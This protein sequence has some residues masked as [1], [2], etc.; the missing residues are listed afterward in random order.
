[1]HGD[2]SMKF[3]VKKPLRQNPPAN[4]I[5]RCLFA[6]LLLLPVQSAAA[7]KAVATL[8]STKPGGSASLTHPTWLPADVDEEMP[9]V[10]ETACS[11]DEVLQEAEESIL[12]FVRNVDRFTA[13]ESLTHQS[14]NKHGQAS[15][16][17]SRT[18]DYVVS[19][20]E[21]RQ[22]HLGVTEYR[23]GGLALNEFPGGIVTNGLP[24]LVLIFHP[25][26]AP[27]YEMTCEGLARSNDQLAWQVH[28]RQWPDKP[29]ELKTYQSGIHGASYPVALKGRAWISAESYQ[30]VRMETDL[31]APVPQIQLLAEHTDVEYGPVKFRE[32]D[33]NLWLPLSA[34]VYFAWRRQQV[35][36]R[37]SFDHYMLF[38]VGDKQRINTPPSL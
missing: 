37:H 29:N 38:T 15:K 32:A 20:H 4:G 12:E 17:V 33:V 6:F 22:G 24:A 23:N 1:M 9:P 8:S 7:Q 34:E 28:F 2:P 27:S 13:T 14:I 36:R 19:I 35:H 21:V 31:V 26:Y 18:F 5:W 11:V 16:A 25:Y 3:L 30:I 10:E